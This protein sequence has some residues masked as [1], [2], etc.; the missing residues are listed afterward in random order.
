[1]PFQRPAI[2]TLSRQAGR[3]LLR[4]VPFLLL[5]SFLERANER[6]NERTR[7]DERTISRQQRARALLTFNFKFTPRTALVTRKGEEGACLT[8]LLKN[9]YIYE[10]KSCGRYSLLKCRGRQRQA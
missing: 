4:L 5:P 8:W 3:R 1:M 9:E 7:T 2:I 10:L 6:T